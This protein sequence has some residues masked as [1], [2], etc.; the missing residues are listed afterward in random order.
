[1]KRIIALIVVAIMMASLVIPSGAAIIITEESADKTADS[2]A[3][4][5]VEEEYTVTVPDALYVGNVLGA[6]ITLNANRNAGNTVVVTVSSENGFKLNGEEDLAYEL[7]ANR[8]KV[9]E[10]GVVL[11]TT[12]MEAVT[13]ILVAVWAEGCSA[14][15]AAGTY[16]DT[17]TFTVTAA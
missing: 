1:M 8:V 13:A 4:Y 6:N 11:Q 10:G 17:L 12:G 9:S 3:V 5:V 14:P 16:T 7:K 2:T 15:E